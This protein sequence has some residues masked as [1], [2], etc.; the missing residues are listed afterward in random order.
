MKNTEILVFLLLLVLQLSSGLAYA[1]QP[2]HLHLTWQ[3][4][5]RSTVVVSW[6]TDQ[7]EPSIV[8]Y[9]PNASYGL[10]TRAQPGTIHHVE[11]SDLEPSTTYHFSCGSDGGWSG[12]LTFRTAPADVS[13]PF[14][15]V[16]LGDSRSK[17]QT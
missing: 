7:V 13:D 5:A 8:R 15:F 11:L 3:H 1:S 16:V 12:D 10:I 14:T 2:H 6:R 17:M 9:G 4:D